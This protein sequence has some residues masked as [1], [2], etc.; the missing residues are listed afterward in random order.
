MQVH[1]ER[2]QRSFRIHNQEPS[3]GN[4]RHEVCDSNHRR[5]ANF[6]PTG[7]E[8]CLEDP[9]KQPV[10]WCTLVDT[11]KPHHAIYNYP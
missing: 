1:S 4:A 5:L 2:G 7:L 8:A 3:T 10:L 6:S 11:R 9:T